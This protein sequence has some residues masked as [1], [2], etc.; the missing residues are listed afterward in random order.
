M[1]LGPLFALGF[2]RSGD[3]LPGSHIKDAGLYP[4]YGGNGMRGFADYY[5]FA[6]DR[7]LIGRVGALCGNIHA[8][9]GRYW[10]T[11]HALVF[12]PTGDTDIRWLRYAMESLDLGKLS[13]AT[14][15]PVITATAVG[16]QRL[17]ICDEM[18]QRRIA[19]YLDAETAEMDAMSAQLDELIERVVERKRGFVRHLFQGVSA[20]K[21]SVATVCAEISGVGFPISY[22]GQQDLEIP[23]YKVS[24]LSMLD[25]DGLICDARNSISSETASF[26][27][28]SVV[29][30]RSVLLAKIGAAMLLGRFVQNRDACAIDNNMLALAPHTDLVQA[31]FLGYAMQMVDIEPLV[32][33]GPVPSMN[34]PALRGTRI[35]LPPLAE[36]RRIVARLDEETAKIDAMIADVTKLRELIAERRSALITDVVTGRKQV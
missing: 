22:Q 7:L 21:A 4:V 25:E 16:R 17:L 5:N 30:P 26:L 1:T 13:Q 3:T 24:S 20:D 6:G 32:N 11:E 12:T 10:A 18:T 15:Q 14:A 8:V 2:I 23:F 29:P 33:P 19:D 9:S 34:M 31:D 28:V 36:Q 35:P 27:R